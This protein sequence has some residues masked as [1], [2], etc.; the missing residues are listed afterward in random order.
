MIINIVESQQLHPVKKKSTTAF[1]NNPGC[2]ESVFF[3]EEIVKFRIFSKEH[4]IDAEREEESGEARIN[5]FVFL[6]GDY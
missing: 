3:V 4:L 2:S 5:L 1:L 6:V